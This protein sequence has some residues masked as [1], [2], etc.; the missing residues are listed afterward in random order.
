MTVHVQVPQN[1][2]AEGI[3][4]AHLRKVKFMLPAGLTV[5]RSSANGLGSCSAAQIGF[6]ELSNE[7]QL[8]RYDLPPG[9]FSGSF[10]VSFKGQSTAPIAATGIAVRG[11]AGD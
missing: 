2:D 3:A 8:I 9:R 11:H 4:A 1:K 10:I 5:N 6:T 7:R